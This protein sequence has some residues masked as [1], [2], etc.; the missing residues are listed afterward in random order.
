M[1]ATALSNRFLT[2]SVAAGL[3]GMSLGLGMGMTGDFRLAP[4]HAHLNLLGFVSMFLYGLFYRC[5]PQAA[6]GVLPRVQFWLAA[7][8]LAVMVP[9]L[10]FVLL[11]HGGAEPVVGLGGTLMISALLT[12][13]VVA[14][15]SQRG[16]V[17]PAAPATAMPVAAG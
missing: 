9:A 17:A 8:G 6:E 3:C 1:S 4:A 10:V 5:V 14:L 7:S 15:R 12:F 16:A 13:A 11:G 2:I